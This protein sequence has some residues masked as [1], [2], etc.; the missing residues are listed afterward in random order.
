MSTNDGCPDL[1]SGFTSWAALSL[2]GFRVLRWVFIFTPEAF[3][4]PAF[5]GL[6]KAVSLFFPATL[7]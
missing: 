4:I 3:G 7:F 6:P 5:H 1:L 2:L